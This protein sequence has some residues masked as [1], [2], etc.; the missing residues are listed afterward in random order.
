M[1]NA[2]NIIKKHPH[3]VLFNDSGFLITSVRSIDQQRGNHL[4]FIHN[5]DDKAI[6]SF[7]LFHGG[8]II[9]NYDLFEKIDD[10]DEY[11]RYRFTIFLSKNPRLSFMKI[12]KSFFYDRKKKVIHPSAQ[13][14]D[15]VEMGAGTTIHANVVI[16]D[17]VRIGKN[18]KIK[19]GAVIGGNGFGYE[20]DE[21]NEWLHFPHIGTVVIGDNVDIGSNTCIDRG[22]LDDT[23][24]SDGVKIDNN[25]HIAHNVFIG[26]SS[27]IIANSMIA[28]SVRIGENCWISPQSAIRD[29]I[30][31]GD[32]VLVGMG[33]VVVKDIPSNSKVKG[34]P[35]RIF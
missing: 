35:A 5:S 4:S 25:V 31:I 29:N 7:K 28:G 16:Y 18:C 26:E 33:S 30:T 8:A 24:I 3:V 19:A 21:N 22:T 6:E 1:L 2:T 20:K 14:G 17:G 23:V 12:V 13:I 32:N 15:N 9:I 10:I 11:N 27:L 34:V